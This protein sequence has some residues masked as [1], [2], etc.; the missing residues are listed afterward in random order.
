M[1][2]PLAL[3]DDV[4]K[5]LGISPWNVREMINRGGLGRGTITVRLHGNEEDAARNLNRTENVRVIP[6]SDPDFKRL[7]SRRNDSESINRG[8]VDSLY[9][10]R[11]HS[12]GDS[13]QQVNLLGYALMVNSLALLDARERSNPALAA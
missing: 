11:A 4:V 1:E 12:I 13:R 9:L 2:T 6:H 3:F 10:G 8:L 7:Y 5:A